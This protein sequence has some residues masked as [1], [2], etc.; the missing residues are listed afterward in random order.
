[1]WLIP[2][3]LIVS[4]SGVGRTKRGK[5]TKWMVVVDGQ[6]IPLESH[7]TSA[8]PHEVT[9]IETTLENVSV[10][11]PGPGRPRKNPNRLITIQ[12]L[13]PIRCATD[14]LDAASN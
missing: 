12:P 8:S 14:W 1:M 6:G 10:P 7:L 13:T 4:Y 11:R 2:S 5:G 9:L 3:G